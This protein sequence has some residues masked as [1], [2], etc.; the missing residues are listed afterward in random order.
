MKPKSGK[1][2]KRPLGVARDQIKHKD[3]SVILEAIW[4]KE[5]LNSS[6]GFRPGKSLHK[7]L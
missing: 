5:F 7:P 4:E 1:Y 6:Y 2:D 3:L